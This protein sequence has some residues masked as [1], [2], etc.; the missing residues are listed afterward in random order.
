MARRE[1]RLGRRA[2]ARRRLAE[3]AKRE[4]D[5]ERQRRAAAAA[6]R[7]RTGQPRRGKAPQPVEAPPDDNAQSN[8]TEP[9]LHSRRTTNQ[10]WEYCGNAQARVDAAC[11]IIVACD[12]SAASHATQQA[13]P[14]AQAILATLA[15]AGIHLPP[16][17]SGA[18]E[19]I[20]ATLDQGSESE[21]AVPALE[22]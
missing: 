3:H 18:T 12:V 4:A 9:A 19:A 16:A 17:E 7:K 1:P 14:L 13:A 11:P 22:T 6:D 2:A 21:A 15:D 20:P 10:G 5:A 8:C